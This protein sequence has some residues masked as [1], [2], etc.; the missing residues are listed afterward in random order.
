MMIR[1]TTICEICYWFRC[2]A[3]ENVAFQ[4]VEGKSL[5]ST[6]FV[7]K[8]VYVDGS[9]IPSRTVRGRGA[10]AGFTRGFKCTKAI[11]A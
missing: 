5:L 4:V 11:S 6:R 9:L 1:S 7:I 2:Y 3:F 8:V 10:G